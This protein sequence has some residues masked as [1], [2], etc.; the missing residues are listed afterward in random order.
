[1]D[2]RRA[3]VRQPVGAGSYPDDDTPA[4]RRVIDR[5]VAPSIVDILGDAADRFGN[6]S[7][8][9]RLLAVG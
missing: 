6:F 4:A 9:T 1:V 8:G 5:L 3:T 7:A 2:L